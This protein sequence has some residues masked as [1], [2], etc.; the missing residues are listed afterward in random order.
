MLP[1]VAANLVLNFSY[2][3]MLVVVP[4]QG[5]ALGLSTVRAASRARII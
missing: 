3:V 4:L 1:V 5:A 2:A